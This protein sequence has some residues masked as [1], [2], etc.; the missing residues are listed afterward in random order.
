[1][2]IFLTDV[3]QGKIFNINS[4]TPDMVQSSQKT[5]KETAVT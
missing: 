3:L 2:D 1:M 5:Y 4:H